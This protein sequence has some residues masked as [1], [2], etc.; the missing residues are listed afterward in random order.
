MC[1]PA[2]GDAP[3]SFAGILL[4]LRLAL[5][6][7]PPCDS[8]L[9]SRC[10]FSWVWG[11]RRGREEQG[12]REGGR[13][14]L[15][16]LLCTSPC[17]CTQ[18]PQNSRNPISGAVR[19]RNCLSCIPWGSALSLLCLPASSAE[20]AGIRSFLFGFGLLKME[21]HVLLYKTIK[22]RPSASVSTPC[23]GR[24]RSRTP[25]KHHLLSLVKEPRPCMSYS[26][27]WPSY[28]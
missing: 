1:R 15:R 21:S 2:R 17:T 3:V 7:L 20:W 14:F 9:A 6:A 5:E 27:H 19:G 28:L 25:A 24:S 11:G 10:I 8:A 13:V 18:Q 4:F 12:R 23:A 16:N 26:S 22:Q